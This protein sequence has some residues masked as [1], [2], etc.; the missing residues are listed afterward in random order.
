MKEK[1]KCHYN[2]K[3]ETP[4][5]AYMQLLFLSSSLKEWSRGTG[6]STDCSSRDPRSI[7]SNGGS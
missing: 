3:P 7:P 2:W 6:E 4:P 1:K 5:Q